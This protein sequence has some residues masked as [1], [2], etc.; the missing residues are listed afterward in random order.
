MTITKEQ[1]EEV[2]VNG[3]NEKIDN[4]ILDYSIPADLAMCACSTCLILL[5]LMARD[6]K[7]L[8]FSYVQKAFKR[9]YAYKKVEEE[10]SQ[11]EKIENA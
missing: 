5:G 10:I 11:L 8:I 6:T 1:V 3:V 9:G 4:Y 2:L 7:K